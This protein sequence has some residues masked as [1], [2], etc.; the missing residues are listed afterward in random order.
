MSNQIQ[1]GIA[2][3]LGKLFEKIGGP[4]AT[5]PAIGS[6]PRPVLVAAILIAGISHHARARTED[7]KPTPNGTPVVHKIVG[8]ELPL[9]NYA[10]GQKIYANDPWGMTMVLTFETGIS[11][12]ASGPV[13]LSVDS[14]QSGHLTTTTRFIGVA[15]PY[16]THERILWTQ[17]RSPDGKVLWAASPFDKPRQSARE[18]PVQ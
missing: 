7:P 18:K 6:I 16:K 4:T 11:P 12:Q 10:T 13:I 15:S 14:D 1:I 2:G 9:R 5:K 3:P 17:I 8:I